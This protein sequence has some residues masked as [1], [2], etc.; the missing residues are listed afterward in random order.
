MSQ[1]KFLVPPLF[2]CYSVICFHKITHFCYCFVISACWRTSRMLFWFYGYK[3]IFKL[4]ECLKN[5]H[6]TLDL[7]SKGS[8]QHFI[9]F[10]FCF[11]EFCTK[12]DTHALL[13]AVRQREYDAQHKHYCCLRCYRQTKWLQ[14]GV[15]YWGNSG[16]CPDILKKFSSLCDLKH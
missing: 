3:P 11:C 10:S 16:T 1:K 14:W 9:S 15:T 13:Q 12:F 6:M 4:V 2:L 5:L 7:L 8:V